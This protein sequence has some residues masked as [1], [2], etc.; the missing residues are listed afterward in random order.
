MRGAGFEVYARLNDVDGLFRWPYPPAFFPWIIAASTLSGILELPFHA[1]VQLPAIASD[2]AI[3]LLVQSY[4]GSRGASPRTRLRA[5]AL[6][7]LGPSFIAISGYHGQIDSLAILPAVAGLVIW[8][9][10]DRDS[11]A[12]IAGALIG[13]SGAFKTVPAL[14]VLAL[15][16]T[17]RNP[18]EAIRM[19]AATAAVPLAMLAPFLAA[20][21]I[22]TARAFTYDGLSGIG[23]LSLVLQPSRAEVWL[24][25]Y[26]FLPTGIGRTLATYA[27]I[28]NGILAATA[29]FLLRYRPRP[30]DA[31]VI[32]W[33]AFY[34]FST[35][36]A[37]HYLVWGM[38][39]FLLAGYLRAPVALQ[40][41]VLVPTLLLYLGPWQD[42]LAVLVY[43]PIMVLVWVAMVGALAILGRRVRRESGDLAPQPG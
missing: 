4:L 17:S 32:L 18:A 3:A 34:G 23:G 5:A 8:E 7:A 15:L 11:R 43:V 26:Q 19:L 42:P 38:P 24:M 40:V 35:G 33:L 20:E 37:L 16:P 36:F 39:F 21:P 9:R 2:A 6:V 28:I 13:L 1:L 10:S 27:T 14:L 30:A 12:L 41:A 29:I 31:A 25:T 22:A